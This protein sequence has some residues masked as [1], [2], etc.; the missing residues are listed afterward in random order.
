MPTVATRVINVESGASV[1]VG[2]VTATA[3][4]NPASSAS[5]IALLKGLLTQLQGAGSGSSPFQIIGYSAIYQQ[6]VTV[7]VAGTPVQMASQACHY[8]FVF[9]Y[10]TNTDTIYIG[11]SLVDALSTPALGAPLE[12]GGCLPLPVNNANLLYVDAKVSG[13]G[14]HVLAF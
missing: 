8:V 6:N 5:I 14:C 11:T 7:T 9:P 10:D 12:V 2:P 4:T 13:E 3:V 1:D